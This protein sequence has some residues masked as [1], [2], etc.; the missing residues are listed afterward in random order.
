MNAAREE[1]AFLAVSENRVAVLSTLNKEP[2]DRTELQQRAAVERVTLGRILND[3]EDRGW[4][5]KTG[6]E[7]AL[8]PIGEMILRDFENLLTTIT[9][10]RKL[11]SVV[12]WLPT[13]EMPFDLRHLGSADITLPTTTDPAAPTRR[14]GQC[15]KTT[16][17][18]RLLMSFIVAEVVEACWDATINGVQQLEAVFTAGVLETIRA[19]PTMSTKLRE[20][21][22]L[23]TVTVYRSD[24]GFPFTMEVLDD[25][26]AFGVTDDENLPRA[27]FETGDEI[28]RNWV[29]TT[30]E[31]YK[32]EAV[33]IDP[34]E[35]GA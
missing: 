15:L 22:S 19:D 14:A 35:F 25:I 13:D 10:A 2:V 34:D 8:T 5:R 6:R 32:Q 23:D 30:F 27:Y 9:T 18:V 12:Q 7:Y 16:S 28:V 3:F 31:Q 24:E 1:I 4:I 26:A 20:M 29:V 33:Q 17:N 21:L 11:D